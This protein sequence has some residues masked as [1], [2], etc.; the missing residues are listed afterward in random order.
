MVNKLRGALKCVAVKAPGFGDR[1]QEMLED[2]AIITGGRVISEDLGAKLEKVDLSQVGRAQRIVADKENTKVI[3]GLGNNSLI[4][5]RKSS[6]A[7][8]STRPRATMTATS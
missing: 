8:R 7:C 6:F 2:I 5:A 4:E 1:R 3:G